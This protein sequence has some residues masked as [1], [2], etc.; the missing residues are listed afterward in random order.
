MYLHECIYKYS[1][2][3]LLILSFQYLNLNFIYFHRNFNFFVQFQ[4]FCAISIFYCYTRENRC[5]LGVALVWMKCC[6][7]HPCRFLWMII[8]TLSLFERRH[9]V[10]DFGTFLLVVP[11]LLAQAKSNYKHVLLTH[12][13]IEMMPK[14]D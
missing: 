2:V 7:S 14:W 1:L 10:C 6:V 11:C 5:T 9:W 12:R 4:F 13:N 8:I 3:L